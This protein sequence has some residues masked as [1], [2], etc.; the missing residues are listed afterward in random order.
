MIQAYDSL[1]DYTPANSRPYGGAYAIRNP[2]NNQQ[3]IVV[4]YYT[5][6]GNRGNMLRRGMKLTTTNVAVGSA[7]ALIDAT[8][9]RDKITDPKTRSALARYLVNS[10][11]RIFTRIDLLQYCKVEFMR[12]F[13]DEAFRY[14]NISLSEGNIAVDD[15][16]EKCLN[17]RFDIAS[18]TVKAEVDN[19]DFFTYLKINVELRKSFSWKINIA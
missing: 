18:E 17:I 14:C 4:T 19:S 6:N 8:G 13:G 1:G 9:G 10:N 2:R 3:P 12:C 11:D 5:T 15:H 7:E 16:V